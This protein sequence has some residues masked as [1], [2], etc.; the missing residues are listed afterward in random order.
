M[1][2]REQVEVNKRTDLLDQGGA[3]W[4]ETYNG[5]GAPRATC[6]SIQEARGAATLWLKTV[7]P[8]GRRFPSLLSRQFFQF[9]RISLSLPCR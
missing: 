4:P 6:P 7:K 3:W 8:S 2:S 1:S 5:C 9:L